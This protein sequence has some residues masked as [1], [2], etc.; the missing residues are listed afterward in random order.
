MIKNVPMNGS[1]GRGWDQN[2][3]EEP[4]FPTRLLL[5]EYFPDKPVVLE[6]IDGHALIVNRI[7]LELAGVVECE[8]SSS[9]G[10]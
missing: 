10:W 5:D 1:L 7:A 8:R 4:R 2:D 9:R 3:W 6:R